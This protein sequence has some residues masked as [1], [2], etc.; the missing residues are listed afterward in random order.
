[1]TP[2]LNGRE[3]RPLPMYDWTF[4]ARGEPVHIS[5]AQRGGLYQCPI[6]GRRM[7]ARLGDVKQH[8]FAYEERPEGGDTFCSPEEVARAVG[9]RWLENAL[10]A[11]LESGQHVDLD[12]T[13]PLCGEHHHAN[14]LEGV[15][16]V[17][18]RAVTHAAPPDVALVEAGGRTLALVTVQQPS[19]HQLEAL[20]QQQLLVLVV[21]VAARRH[22][23]IHLE[24]L[25]DGAEISGGVCE[26]ERRAVRLGLVS[27]P[28]TLRQLLVAA[29]SVPPYCAHGPL[30]DQDGLTHI[31]NLGERRLW[32][33]P[34][35]WRSAVGGML[36]AISPA[37]HILS[38][39]WPQPDGATIALY[40]VT[41]SLA[42]PP[43]MAVAVRRFAPGE[44]VYARLS[45]AQ[46]RTVRATADDIARNL[47]GL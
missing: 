21:D 8:H 18:R 35:R 17:E 1:M 11:C 12:W 3:S 33:P 16:R 36:H 28:N 15:A 44:D 38:Q 4:D 24:R 5:Q 9:S 2:L 26:T 31:L 23:L 6:T 10:R 37:L 29:V 47:A 39:E 34:A 46:F 19:A 7:I 20:A 40:Y 22:A 43:T 45:N 14:L 32:L 42:Q 13:C 30:T 27:D 25:L 41:L